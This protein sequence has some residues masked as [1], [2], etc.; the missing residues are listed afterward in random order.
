MNSIEWWRI[1]V[2]PS[3]EKGL[4]HV[5]KDDNNWNELVI[6][7]TIERIMRGLKDFVGAHASEHTLAE[8]FLNLVSVCRMTK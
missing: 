1:I 3:R 7:Y 8:R 4:L 5:I 6:S 2:T